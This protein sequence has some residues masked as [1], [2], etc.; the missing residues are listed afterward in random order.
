MTL[1]LISEA[2][3]LFTCCVKFDVKMTDILFSFLPNLHCTGTTARRC[4]RTG[5]DIA[6][7]TRPNLS[8]QVIAAPAVPD[9]C[10]W[11]PTTCQPGQATWRW[12]CGRLPT[13]AT[14]SILLPSTEPANG[15]IGPTCSDGWAEPSCG[16]LQREPEAARWSGK[17]F[18]F[19]PK[20]ST[21][22]IIAHTCIIL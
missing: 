5:N 3:D 12:A 15:A 6:G 21:L 9:S 18:A 2:L 4:Q 1:T 7:A 20:L 16:L 10:T 11:A 13:G 22:N 17:L 8:G 14:T 19:A